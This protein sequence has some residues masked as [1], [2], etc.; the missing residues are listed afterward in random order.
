MSRVSLRL[1]SNFGR[2]TEPWALM[3]TGRIREMI[4][5]TFCV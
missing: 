2:R 5:Q 4:G 1:M 3:T